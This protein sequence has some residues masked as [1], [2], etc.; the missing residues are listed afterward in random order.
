VNNVSFFKSYITV[1]RINWL[2]FAEI[3]LKSLFYAVAYYFTGFDCGG[4]YPVADKHLYPNGSQDQ[5]HPQCGG[6]NCRYHLAAKGIWVIGFFEKPDCIKNSSKVPTGCSLLSRRFQ[7]ADR[8]NGMN[9]IVITGQSN[10]PET[11]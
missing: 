7:K 9:E 2:T 8:F 10:L 3:I 4:C 5:K 1:R 6:G 11:G